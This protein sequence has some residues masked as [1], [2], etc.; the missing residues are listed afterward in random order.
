MTPTNKPIAQANAPV[1][2]TAPVV[3]PTTEQTTEETSED[4]V[5]DKPTILSHMSIRQFKTK[6]DTDDLVCIRNPK[7]GKLFLTADNGKTVAC[8]SKNYKRAEPAEMIEMLL[9]DTGEV[10]W[11]LHNQNTENRMF[12]L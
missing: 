4:I 11:C 2:P 6:H 3:E 9:P 8:I 10:L 7:T 5:I 12:V 1:A